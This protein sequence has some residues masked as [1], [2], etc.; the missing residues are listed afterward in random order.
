MDTREFSDKL[1]QDPRYDVSGL[2]GSCR[3]ASGYNLSSSGSSEISA[4]AYESYQQEA[5]F[6]DK[7]QEATYIAIKQ[8]FPGDQI[9]FFLLMYLAKL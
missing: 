6:F 1:Y 3:Q 9:E 4:I 7:E 5:V 8:L 2:T